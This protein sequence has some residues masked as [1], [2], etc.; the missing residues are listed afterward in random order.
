MLVVAFTKLVSEERVVAAKNALFKFS[1]LSQ[2]GDL[3]LPFDLHPLQ[4]IHPPH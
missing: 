3:F 1:Q 4:I 2:H